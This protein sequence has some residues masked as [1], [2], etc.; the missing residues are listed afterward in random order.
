[1]SGP[2]RWD[3]ARPDRYRNFRAFTHRARY[4]LY[5]IACIASAPI[6]S[7]GV[8]Y[9]VNALPY[10]EKRRARV[11]KAKHNFDLALDC[12]SGQLDPVKQKSV[13]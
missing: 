8:E 7:Q 13:F 5:P 4:F 11:E 12:H 3:S 9:V 10:W 6:V 1:M 2:Y